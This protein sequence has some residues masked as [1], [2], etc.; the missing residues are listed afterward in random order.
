MSAKNLAPVAEQGLSALNDVLFER[1]GVD[2]LRNIKFFVDE[3]C[4]TK[5]GL[6][7]T[8]AAYIDNR[9]KGVVQTTD[10]YYEVPPSDL[11]AR[12]FKAKFVN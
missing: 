5:D 9:L 8:A 3:S 6:A 10:K 2:D 11:T 1:D 12:Q 7:R 4:V